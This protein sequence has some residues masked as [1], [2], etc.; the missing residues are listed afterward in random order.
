MTVRKNRNNGK[1]GDRKGPIRA[2]QYLRMST[3]HQQYSTENQADAIAHYAERHGL[4]IVRTYA[5]EG[6]SGLQLD[7]REALQSLIA[8]ATQ[9]RADYDMLLVY[10]VSRFGRFQ[11]TDESAYYEY[12]CKKAGI[13]VEYCA[14]QFVNDGSMPSSILKMIRR[15][16][17]GDYSR[18]LSVKVFAGQCRLI[19]MG[20]RQGG[21]AGYGLRRMRIDQTGAELGLLERGQHKCLQTDRVILKPGPENEIQ[22]VQRIYR[23][24]VDKGRREGEIAALLNAEGIVTD[25][26]RPWRASTVHQVLTNE[27]YIGN[28]VFNRRSFKLKAQRVRNPPEEWIRAEGVFTPIV[29]IQDYRA[30][31]AIIVERSRRFSDEEI[32]NHLKALHARHGLLSAIVIDETHHGPSSGAIRHRFGSLLRAYALIGYDPGRDYAYIEDNRHLRRMFPTVVE[33]TLRRIR[34]L[35]GKTRRELESGLV[36]VNEEFSLSLVIARCETT[37]AGAHRWTIRLET[38]LLPD[39]SV[40]VRMAPG[41]R[42]ILDYYLLPAIDMNVAKLRLAEDNGIGLDAY[43]FTSLERLFDLTRR[44]ALREVV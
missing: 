36:V 27:K 25:L 37:K 42:D 31:Q 34:D 43:R 19:R 6:I 21:P 38:G 35:G 3:E 5:D 16:Q 41:N 9:G 26:G 14:E 1:S 2:A 44:I 20:Y 13:R 32:L 18:D 10:D 23:L 40:A 8:D 4:E 12:L 30:A 15:S 28:N 11:D 33:D 24:F 17:A 39:I 29:D 7:R 22:T